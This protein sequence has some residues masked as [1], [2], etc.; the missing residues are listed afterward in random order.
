LNTEFVE[1]REKIK[2]KSKFKIKI[3]GSRIHTVDDFGFVVLEIDWLFPRDSGVYKCVATNNW[4]SDST[5]ATIKVKGIETQLI[6]VNRIL[7]IINFNLAKKDIILDSQLPPGMSS[8]SL[9]DLEYPLLHEAI[10][11][12]VS[13]QTPRFIT[14]IKPLENLVE[15]DNIHFECR[16]E[17]TTDG[18]LTV[19]WYHNGEPLRSGHRHKT[20]HDFG[21]VSLDILSVYPEVCHS[22]IVKIQ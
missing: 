4:G 17:P 22:N 8:E 9:K 11:E 18:R 6:K 20:I 7:V 5:Q 10:H 3:L 2:F 16:L 15:G 12:D 14:Q 21:F 13:L 19:D 1:K